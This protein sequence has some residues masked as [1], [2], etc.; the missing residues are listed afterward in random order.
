MSQEGFSSTNLARIA[1]Q[2]GRQAA[3]VADDLSLPHAQSVFDFAISIAVVHH[4]FTP[5]RRIGAISAIL[6]TLRPCSKRSSDA[7]GISAGGGALMCVWA[8]EQK[9]SCRG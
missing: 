3:I 7:T 8:L 9:F 5:A 4:L 1:C 2:H 6:E